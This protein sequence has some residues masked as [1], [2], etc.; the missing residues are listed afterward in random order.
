MGF[1]LSL[2]AFELAMG[3]AL[4][5]NVRRRMRM[6][7]RLQECRW[8]SIEDRLAALREELQR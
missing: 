3:I 1:S 8:L 5:S 4:L 7:R 2:I 6:S